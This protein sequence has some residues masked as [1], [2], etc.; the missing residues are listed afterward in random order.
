[1]T[2]SRTLTEDYVLGLL[3]PEARREVEARL[4]APDGPEDEA[5][6]AAVRAASAAHGW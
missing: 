4:A 2:Y 1:M 6:I 5:L 3:S